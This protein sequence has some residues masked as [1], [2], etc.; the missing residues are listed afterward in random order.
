MEKSIARLKDISRELQL[1]THSI[2]LLG[3]DQETYMPPAAAEERADQ[4]SL[5][6][7]MLHEKATNPEIGELLAHAGADGENPGGNTSLPEEDGGLVRAMFRDFGRRIKL[8]KDLVMRMAKQTSIGQQIWAE[9][10][11]R[12]EFSLFAPEL[13][14]I[15]SLTL[16]K[17]ECLGYSEHVYD[18]LLDEYE[19]WMKTSAAEAVFSS[20]KPRL[21]KILDKIRGARQVD[22]SFLLKNY[23]REKQEAFGRAVISD[24]G[25]DVKRGRL[26]QS[27]HPFT[28][29][30][31]KDD[32]R[33]T[34]RY[35]ENFFKTGIFGIIHECGHGLYELGF[36]D[37]IK[38]T[39]LA[40]G[41]SLGIHESQSRMWEN[42]IG[43]SMAFWEHYFPVLASCFPENL[44]GVTPER[45]YRAVN[46]V[47]P[48]F[49]RVEADEVTYSLH[50]ILRF[51]L[52]TRMVTGKIP[53]RDLPEAWNSL[54]Q[55][56][57]GIRPS[58]DFDGVLQD[59]H[60]SMGGIGYFPTYSLGNLYGAQ[61]YRALK[62][63]LPD[64][65]KLIA[66]GDFKPLLSWLR[67]NIHRH[68]RIYTADELC[69]KVTGES[70]NPDYFISYLEDKFS[71][72]YEF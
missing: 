29:T 28:T 23:P 32:V 34:T 65:E 67:E 50:I 64:A 68:G 5:L 62:K 6:E 10:R 4:L 24:L 14:K 16:E 13:E 66:G 15:L 61:F 59:V 39:A 41:T 63:T 33:L 3:W 30:L 48:S 18:A 20:L 31:G 40:D 21:V 9:A 47:E 2:A 51:T 26:D 70:L 54:F 1:L 7:G 55:E 37:S 22:D 60:W 8:T 17:A 57:L 56:L 19:P 43:R 46:K 49:I 53:V 71:K 42:V 52:E 11:K 69:R 45:F 44:S 12:N 25:W 72:V 27:T 38:G 36:S 35:N 58:S